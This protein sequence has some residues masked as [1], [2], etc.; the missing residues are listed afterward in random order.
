MMY[1][2]EH[3]QME[4]SLLFYTY[5]E[6]KNINY[7]KGGIEAFLLQCKFIIHYDMLS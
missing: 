5:W 4:K 2:K 3:K 7:P 1:T 6:K